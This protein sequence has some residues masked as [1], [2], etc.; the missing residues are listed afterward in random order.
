[1]ERGLKILLKNKKIKC[2]GQRIEKISQ[3]LIVEAYLDL[4]DLKQ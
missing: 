1:M 2:L 3:S 4:E